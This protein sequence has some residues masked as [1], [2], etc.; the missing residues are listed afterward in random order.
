M[1]EKDNRHAK[2][3]VR[4]RILTLMRKGYEVGEFKGVDVQ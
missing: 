1:K 3:R 4:K 2:E